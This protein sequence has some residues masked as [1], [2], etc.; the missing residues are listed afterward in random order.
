MKP[1]VIML[2]D[3]HTIALEDGAK[4]LGLRTEVLR[5]GGGGWH[6][7]KFGWSAEGFVPKGTP[8]GRS[9]LEAIRGRLGVQNVFAVGAPVITTV[10]FHLALMVRPMGWSGHRMMGLNGE[11]PK[12]G[13][14]MSAAFAEAYV[15][16]FRGAHFRLL[17]RLAREARLIVVPPP[18]MT[19]E[20]NIARIRA[21]VI[22][23]IRQMGIE[24]YDPMTELLADEPGFPAR[25]VGDDPSHA[26][27]DYGELVM[28]GL[29]A[30]GKI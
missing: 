18:P 7:G 26:T 4:R 24:V 20:P 29:R 17:R 19:T 16:H 11:T 3:S 23:R 1:D 12:D 22:D 27:A 21:L 14:L 13:L 9:A 30:A 10:G 25:F 6:E 28:A 2:G 8:M 15:E 5:F